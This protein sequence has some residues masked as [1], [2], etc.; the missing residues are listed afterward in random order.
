MIP[1]GVFLRLNSTNY[2]TFILQHFQRITAIWSYLI[3]LRC[4]LAMVKFILLVFQCEYVCWCVPIHLGKTSHILVLYK[5]K[6]RPPWIYHTLDHYNQA[7][8]SDTHTH[9][10]IDSKCQPQVTHITQGFNNG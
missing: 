9:T 7:V 5:G 2:G 6:S 8:G 4:E 3:C 10:H 1:I